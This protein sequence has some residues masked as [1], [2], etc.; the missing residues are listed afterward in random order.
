MKKRREKWKEKGEK[1]KRQ[2]RNTHTHR[3]V[4]AIFIFTANT[5]NW[6]ERITDKVD[7]WHCI[8]EFEKTN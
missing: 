1:I 3:K 8:C 5:E 2:Q 6:R 7:E 4:Q